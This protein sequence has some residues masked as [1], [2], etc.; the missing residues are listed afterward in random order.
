M[1]I[2]VPGRA[3]I[4]VVS[5]SK[6]SRPGTL[7]RAITHATGTPTIIQMNTRD[8]RIEQTIDN[9]LWRFNSNPL[10]ILQGIFHRNREVPGTPRAGA[11][12]ESRRA[13]SRS[14]GTRNESASARATKA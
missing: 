11:V 9:E 13:R 8:A 3:K 14:P 2:P 12:A 7:V 10:E 6:R 5:E 4:S 1:P